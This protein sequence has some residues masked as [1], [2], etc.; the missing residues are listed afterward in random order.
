M[1]LNQMEHLGAGE[2]KAYLSPSRGRYE[3][4][5]KFQIVG[6]ALSELRLAGLVAHHL[7]NLPTLNLPALGSGSGCVGS[8]SGSGSGCVGSGSADSCSVEIVVVLLVVAVPFAHRYRTHAG[9]HCVVVVV[10]QAMM[11][12]QQRLSHAAARRDPVECFVLLPSAF[13]ELPPIVAIVG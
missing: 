12:Q 2:A 9:T 11:Q 4:A 5:R 10:G 8:R 1:G 3:S 7:V 6:I 13:V